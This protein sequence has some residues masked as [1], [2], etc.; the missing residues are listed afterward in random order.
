[1]M[2]SLNQY[3]QEELVDTIKHRDEEAAGRLADLNLLLQPVHLLA[4]RMRES[5][6]QIIGAVDE[7]VEE[8]DTIRTRDELVNAPL[9]CQ[10]SCGLHAG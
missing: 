3:L 10:A 5:R 1:M 6:E 4:Q 9:V 7:V 2:M 8:E